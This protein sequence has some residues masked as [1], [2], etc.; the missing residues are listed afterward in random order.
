MAQ[1]KGKKRAARVTTRVRRLKNSTTS[2]RIKL[3]SGVGDRLDALAKKR[4]TT[5]DVI[6]RMSLMST[7]SQQK[8]VEIDS[9]LQFGKYTGQLMADVVKADPGYVRWCVDN[10][11]HVEFSD[12]VRDALMKVERVY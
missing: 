1:R 9:V 7:L 8:V 10:L 3:P 12:E 11:N 2:I 6:V 4:G 5:A